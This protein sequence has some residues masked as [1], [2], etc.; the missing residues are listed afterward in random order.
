MIAMKTGGLVLT[1]ITAFLLANKAINV[2][3]SSVSK[4]CEASKWR[5]YYKC[6]SKGNAS[7]EPVAPGYSVT[8]ST[9]SGEERTVNSPNAV[10]NTNNSDNKEVVEAIVKACSDA[11]ND[12]G[13]SMIKPVNTQ[14]EASE[15]QGEASEET[16]DDI[17]DNIVY[18]DE[19]DKENE[20]ETV[21]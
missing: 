10:N 6:W 20:D 15:G 9:S 12:L 11:V 13:N 5:N 1:G 17:S 7:G 14:E 4:A 16:S 18:M 19:T 2:V 8:T 21:D 3:S